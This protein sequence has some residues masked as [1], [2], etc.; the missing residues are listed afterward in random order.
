MTPDT[1]TQAEREA[2]NIIE[3]DQNGARSQMHWEAFATRSAAW[4]YAEKHFSRDMARLSVEQEGRPQAPDHSAGAENMVPHSPDSAASDTGAGVKGDVS[5]QAMAWVERAYR[6]FR[7]NPDGQNFTRFNMQV[8]YCAGYEAASPAPTAADAGKVKAIAAIID[9][10][11]CEPWTVDRA[12]QMAAEILAALQA[13]PS[14]EG[15]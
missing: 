7:H 5:E 14:T 13:A 4:A 12:E 9:R 10:N 15:A 1:N 6:V 8:A 2:F 11:K 3:T